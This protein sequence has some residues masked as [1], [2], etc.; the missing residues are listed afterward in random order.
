MLM[1][2]RTSGMIG[3]ARGMPGLGQMLPWV[4]PEMGSD[5]RWCLG[6]ILL[7]RWARFPARASNRS[8]A[9][10]SA[11]SLQVEPLS[12][13]SHFFCDLEHRKAEK[14]MVHSSIRKEHP[15]MDN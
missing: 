9:L 10:V 12:L 11:S 8:A 6:S 5:G 2:P 4:F 13:I 7:I 1:V 3:R 15:V 14:K